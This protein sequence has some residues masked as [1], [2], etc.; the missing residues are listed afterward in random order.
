MSYQLIQG[1][2]FHK[3]HTDV[4]LKC[5]ELDDVQRVLKEFHDGPIGS[6]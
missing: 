6:N 1:H 4:L 2:M 3:H 5:L